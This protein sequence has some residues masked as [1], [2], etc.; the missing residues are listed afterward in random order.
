[1]F[2]FNFYSNISTFNINFSDV[3]NINNSRVGRSISLTY[4]F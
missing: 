4:D 3:I 2:I 1:M